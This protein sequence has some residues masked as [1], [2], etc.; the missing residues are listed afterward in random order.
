MPNRLLVLVR[1]AFDLKGCEQSGVVYHQVWFVAIA[2]SFKKRL[3]CRYA[4]YEVQMCGSLMSF[5]SPGCRRQ[6]L[7]RVVALLGTW[8]RAG[9]DQE[10]A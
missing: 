2:S 10:L 5:F 4:S 6:V 3:P 7:P 1:T 8:S 9:G